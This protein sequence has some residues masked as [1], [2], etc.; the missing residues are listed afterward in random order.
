MSKNDIVKL[1][2]ECFS[3]PDVAKKLNISERTVQRAM[4]ESGY[5]YNRKLKKYSLEQNLSNN[6]LNGSNFAQEPKFDNSGKTI[7]KVNTNDNKLVSRTYSIP[8][9]VERALKMKSVLENKD[10]RDI[11]SEALSEYIEKKYF[12]MIDDN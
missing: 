3:I 11:V 8:Y 4:K 9:K 6:D 2:N 1:Y 12:A 10:C 5:T 7:C